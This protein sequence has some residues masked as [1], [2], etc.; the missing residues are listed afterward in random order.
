MDV[1]DQ[2]ISTRR[3]GSHANLSM[4]EAAF[5][6]FYAIPLTLRIVSLTI[7]DSNYDSARP[8]YVA[9]VACLSV[10]SIGTAL[11]VLPFLSRMSR[12][13]GVL[14]LAV[15]QMLNAVKQYILFTGVVSGAMALGM[16][17]LSRCGLYAPQASTSYSVTSKYS[18]FG[19]FGDAIRHPHYLM[20][21]FAYMAP[22]FADLDDFNGFSGQVIILI[23][24]FITSKVLVSLIMA[25]FTSA[26]G[27]VFKDSEIEYTFLGHQTLFA[28]QHAIDPL[29][30]PFN[31]PIVLFNL[32]R[33]MIL[34]TSHQLKRDGSPP[35]IYQGW[36]AYNDEQ[37]SKE[38]IS[39][40]L[41]VQKYCKAENSKALRTTDQIVSSVQS[42]VKALHAQATARH[43][44]I[45]EL[46]KL[47]L[48][49]SS[50]VSGGRASG[51]ELQAASMA[52]NVASSL[53]T[54]GPATVKAT[55]RQ[56]SNGQATNVEDLTA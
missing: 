55:T 40:K 15:M 56:S 18:E 53:L 2:A 49:L 50:K 54:A 45:T 9:H 11:G 6:W 28:Y 46:K 17:G 21:A 43:D 47:V 32:G 35:P 19:K 34:Y 24:L 3:V 25:I 4:S 36:S 41:F 7:A 44:E 14:V 20:P 22:T 13:F 1:V 42:D 5:S 39:A 33:Y 29:P 30:P 31:M 12:P 52:S 16:L 38:R 26:H 51:S 48:E 27:R 37:P 23:Y 8:L 10:Y